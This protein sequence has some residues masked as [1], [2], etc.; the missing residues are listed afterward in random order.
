MAIRTGEELLRSLVKRVR[1]LERRL[2]VRGASTPAP[3][4]AMTGEGKMWFGL[5]APVGWMLCQGQAI[6]RADYADLFEFLNPVVGTATVTIA[7]PGVW[8]RAGHGLYTGQAVYITTTGALPTGLAQN[9]TYYVI[10]VDANTFRL[11]TTLANANAGT[12]I[13]TTGAQ[14]GVHTI[15]TTFGVGNG[16]TTFNVPDMRGVTPVGL[17]T[18]QAEFDALGQ[19]GGAKTHTL[20]AEELPRHNH[21]LSRNG[22]NVAYS[23][24]GGPTLYTAG[25][26]ATR[27]NGDLTT[28][29]QQTTTDLPHNNLQPYRV[30]NFIIKT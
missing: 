10:R 23:E 29:Y 24:A 13:N 6:S 7:T 26:G 27:A 30:I 4:L 16:A 12:A 1:L 21:P 22:G 28:G 20:V 14:N 17:D 25:F 2:A 18:T 19:G 3:L 9:T 5:A 11:A 8:T 15:R